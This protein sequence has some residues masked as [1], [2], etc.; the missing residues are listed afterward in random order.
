MKIAAIDI[1]TNSTRLLIGEV[2]KGMIGKKEKWLYPTRMGEGMS[3]LGI[4]S[5]V[6]ERNL[7]AFVEAV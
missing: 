2:H 6:I 3:A 1:G 4:P 5:H 7:D